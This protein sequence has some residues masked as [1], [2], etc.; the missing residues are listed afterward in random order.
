M[1]HEPAS[2]PATGWVRWLA[3][4]GLVVLV[5]FLFFWRLGQDVSVRSHEALLAES[6]RNM[7]LDKE[8]RLP[9]RSRPSA[10][11]VP[12][13]NGEPRLRKTPLPYWTVALLANLTGEVDA[14]TARV[15]SAAAAVGTVLVL[16]L[17]VWHVWGRTSGLLAGA[18][19]ATSAGFIVTG[20]AALADMPMTFFTTASLAALWVGVERAGQS[21]FRW[22]FLAGIMAGLSM[23][24]KG[25]APLLVFPLPWLVAVW[26]MVARLRRARR[27]GET[28]RAEWG[29]TLGGVAAAGVAFIGIMLPWPLFVYLHV[30]SAL[31]VWKAESVDRSVGEFGHGEP[32]WFYVLRLPILVAPWTL[33]FGVGLVL[34]LRQAWRDRAE[35]GRLVL[36]AAWLAG[37]LVAF[38]AASGKQDHYILPILPAAAIYTAVAMRRLFAPAPDRLDPHGR[39]LLIAHAVT[40][41]VLGLG[42]LAGGVVLRGQS[43]LLASH[44]P[45]SPLATPAILD[46]VAVLGGMGIVGGLA[47]CLLAVRW[48]L[49]GGQA[50]LFATLVVAF[51]WAW[52]TLVGPTDRASTARAIGEHARSVVP[53]DVPVFAI[54]GAHRVVVFYLGRVLPELGTAANLEAMRRQGRPFYL[55]CED[56]NM[57]VLRGVSGM[58]VIA[59]EVHPIIRDESFWLLRVPAAAAGAP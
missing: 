17:L 53:A 3:P 40:A 10:Y 5:A 38:S 11:V 34:A 18:V 6:A 4:A 1:N 37:P 30:P 28:G 35:R 32:P 56:K 59:H 52:S 39:R 9:D 26:E 7:F 46:A 58:E 24:A 12:N 2:G 50:V 44:G 15:P 19:L 25:P 23:L 47:A 20:R 43:D 55:I 54:P 48:R 8:V 29:W 36:L 27:S 13:F 49:L 31:E 14:W 33:F 51:L 41:V 21:R 57:A 22:L 45:A 16:T 42:A